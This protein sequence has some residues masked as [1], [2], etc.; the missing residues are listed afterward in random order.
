MTD[1]LT[2]VLIAV[3][4]SS[5]VTAIGIYISD[6]AS[7]RINLWKSQLEMALDEIKEALDKIRNQIRDQ[8]YSIE[9][10]SF[11]EHEQR[12]CTNLTNDQN[13]ITGHLESLRK[14]VTDTH[15]AFARHDEAQKCFYEKAREMQKESI[16]S[17]GRLY[18]D[19]EQAISGY[20]ISSTINEELHVRIKGLRQQMESEDRQL[21]AQ[22]CQI[23]E[24]KAM[25]AELRQEIRNSP[26]P[27]QSTHRF[28]PMQL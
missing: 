9:N 7:T 10:L 26:W 22:Q 20:R 2:G 21:L 25:V 13:E 6:L 8:G 3:S 1:I 12:F 27:S 17:L 14:I 23:G 11:G 19:L 15:V 4:I 28:P 24:L 5:A 18:T 16:E